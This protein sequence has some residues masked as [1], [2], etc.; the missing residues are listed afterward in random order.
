MPT[1]DARI[2]K[3]GTAYQTD[4]GMTGN[5]DSV[6]GMDKNNSIKRFLKEDSVKH[7]PSKGEASLSGVI[8]DVCKDTGLALKIK[9]LITGGVL[10]NTK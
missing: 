9:S 10:N 2:L 6:I 3:N 5:Y 8:V 7:F 1:S 4:V